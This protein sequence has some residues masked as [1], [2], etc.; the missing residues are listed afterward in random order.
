MS[1]GGL[2]PTG[3]RLALLEQGPQAFAALGRGIYVTI[4][5]L[6]MYVP[7]ANGLLSRMPGVSAEG[8]AM[9][10]EVARTYDP[11]REVVLFHLLDDSTE[12]LEVYRREGDGSVVLRAPGAQG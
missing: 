6:S 2:A 7:I 9:M 3:V 10:A 4:Q 12:R 5:D 1:D 8:H 11:A